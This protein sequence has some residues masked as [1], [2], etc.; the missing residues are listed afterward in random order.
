MEFQEKTRRENH[1]GHITPSI[2]STDPGTQAEKVINFSFAK[3]NTT[4]TF[5]KFILKTNSLKW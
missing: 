5:L 4:V 3:D 2:L 1:K